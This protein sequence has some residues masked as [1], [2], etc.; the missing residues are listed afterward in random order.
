MAILRKDMIDLES[1]VQSVYQH[2]ADAK[3]ERE[4]LLWYVTQLSKVENGDGELVNWFEG[5]DIE[6]Q[7]EDLYEKFEK[8]E[9]SFE[10][11]VVSKISKNY[12]ILV[13]LSKLFPKDITEFLKRNE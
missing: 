10:F 9:S 4:T 3:A 2:T 1:S 12:R 7:I 6:D 13:L 8:D 11:Q 5:L